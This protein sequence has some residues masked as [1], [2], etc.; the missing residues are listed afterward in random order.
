M[1]SLADKLADTEAILRRSGVSEPRREAS[2]LLSLA[3]GR[4]RTFLITHPEYPLQPDEIESLDN[5]VKRRA[6]REP[7]QYLA[8]T[9]EFC[10]L[11]F[12]VTPDV[13]I[14]RPETEMVVERTIEI[15]GGHSHPLF[16]EVGIGSGC[17]A[18]SVL[19]DLE[20]T[21][22]CGL[23]ISPAAL[24]VAHRNAEVNGVSDRLELR[25]SDVFSALGDERFDLILSNPP[26]VRDDDLA[27][28]QP[29]VRDFEPHVA[30]FGGPEGLS[31]IT[32][33]V[34]GGHRFLKQQGHLL[35]EIGFS[36]SERVASMFDASRW[37]PPTVH[38]D[39]QGIPRLVEAKL[40]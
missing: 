14:P 2:S 8:G 12:I 10:G 11:E 25:E 20:R 19:H 15:L 13:L 4:D 24:A 35:L 29:E 22:A 9:T 7:F 6:L 31:V 21:K 39:F 30:L 16:C 18:I 5:L 17:I 40:K 37:E 38:S 32:Q 26:Y 23:D 28:L 34:D 3:L 36:Q 33:V 27:G 1:S